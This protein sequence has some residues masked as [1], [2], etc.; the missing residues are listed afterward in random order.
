MTT[1]PTFWGSEIIFSPFLTDFAPQVGALSDNSFAIVWEREGGDIV[2]RHFD[3][4]G[5]FT[6]GDFLSALSG[7]TAKALSQPR[8][9]QQTDGRVVVNYTEE[10]AAGDH[11]IRWHSPNETFTPHASSF[12]TETS[13]FDEILLDSTAREGGGAAN[14]YQFTGPG[15]VTNI[16]LRFTDAIGNQAS[17]RIF[18][19]PHTGEVQQNPA[20]A[21]LHTG[22]VTVAYENFTSATGA[23]DIRLHTYA[24]NESDVSGEVPVSAPGA[25]AAFPDVVE[26]RDGSFVVT[27]QQADGIA[28]RHFIGNGTPTGP[29]PLLVPNSAGGFLPKITP[30]NDG[31]YIIAWTA[32]SGTESD[33]SPDLDIFLRRLNVSDQTVGTTVHL[34]Q[35]GDQG[36]FGMS[37]VTLDDGRVILA[38]G[39]ETGDATNITTLNYRILDPREP[40][41]LGT[42]GNDNIVG[43]EDASLISGL[44]GNDRL[45]G[46]EAGD[47]LNGGDGADRLRG[48]GGGDVLNGGPGNDTLDGGSGADRMQGGAGKDVYVV[49][50]PGDRVDE[51]VAGSGGVDTVQSSLS[52]SLAGSAVI[53]GVVERLTLLG[54]DNLNGTGNDLANVI[55]GNSG[56]NRLNGGL[57][58][59]KLNG[60]SGDDRLIGGSGNDR[61]NGGGGNDDLRGEAGLD[62]LL[63]ASGNDRLAGGAGADRL[64]GGSGGDR[65]VLTAVGESGTAAAARDVITD[66]QDGV[67]RIDLSAIDAKLA[68]GGN[69]AFS[70][71]GTAAFTAPGQVHFFQNAGINRTFVEGSVDGDLAP[72][73]RIELVGL[74][75]L[76]GGDFVL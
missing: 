22:F 40:T 34:D 26:L 46:R 19:G 3:E 62:T 39:S 45:T 41:I 14:V 15:D 72:E 23:R 9:L 60:V 75:D 64:T 47:T 49:D 10:F 30:L 37:I 42:N 16:V 52:L 28:L 74:H 69:Q 48:F 73:F 55:T 54:A 12:G 59:D 51:S 57:G 6:S 32:I 66:F 33:G 38:Y 56:N 35:P 8:I 25:N 43:R 53:R 31:G 67:D 29:T 4:L 27:W 5:S 11:D 71:I 50:N 13:P 1:T 21:K 36:L 44:D 70:F 68:V 18:V 17:N 24:P 58:N 65:F 61:L 2:G 63:G 7:A 76:A 20:I